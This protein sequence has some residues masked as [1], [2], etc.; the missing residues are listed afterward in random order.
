ML[1]PTQLTEGNIILRPF[2]FDDSLQL[3]QAVRESLS[4]LKPWMSWAHDAY[5]QLEVR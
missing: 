5:S 1:S 3:Y 4:D 2:H